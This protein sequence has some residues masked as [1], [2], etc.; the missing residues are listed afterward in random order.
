MDPRQSDLPEYNRPPVSEVVLSLQFEPIEGLKTPLFGLLWQRFREYLP[1][2]EEHPPLPHTVEQFGAPVLP[3]INVVVE[4]RPPVPRVWFL[5]SEKT[6]LVQVQQDRFTHNWRKVTGQEPYPRYVSIRQKF[7]EEVTNLIEFL[8]EEN[9]GTMRINQCE[10]TYVNQIE[11]GGLWERFGD[12]S[13]VLLNWK[14]L[15]PGSFLPEAENVGVNTRYVIPDDSGRPLGRLHVVF[16]P[17]W[18]KA[19]YSPIFTMSLTARGRPLSEDLEGAF[20]FLD[21]GHVWIVKGFA[22]L[23]TQTMQDKAWERTR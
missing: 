14:G 16:Q 19:D 20:A 9:V 12:V 13:T 4:E 23:C 3:R 5:T 7:K 6:Q 10:V 22:D 2:I 11:P 15:P 21:L 1:E 17:A 18:K 8:R